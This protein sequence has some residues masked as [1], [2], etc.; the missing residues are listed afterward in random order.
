MTGVLRQVYWLLWKDLLLEVRRRDNLLSM[1]FFGL[2]L[3]FLFSFAFEITRDNVPRMAPGLLW[4]AFMFSGT[5]ALGQ[6]FQGDR[7]N[8]C[9]DALLLAPMD[10]GAYYLAKVLFNF[11]LML[12]LEVFI[13]PLF[14]ILFRLDFWHLLP[15]VFLYTLLGTLGFCVVGV[16]F[17]AV[18][19]RA[20]ARA[21]LLPVLLFPL[22]IPVILATVR[23]LEIILGAGAPQDL[24]PWFRLLVGFDLIFIT[25]GFLLLEWVLDG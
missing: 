25:A 7:E 20:R 16:L 24:V 21:L 12:L 10:R 1:F 19:L 9:L 17:A 6:L 14:G 15:D 11:S 2:S 4:L 5:L 13:L 8:D 3:L 23:T 22:M 18:T